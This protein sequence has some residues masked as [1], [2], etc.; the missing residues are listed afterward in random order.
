MKRFHLTY[1]VTE[2]ML[3]RDFLTAKGISKRT[4]T[5]IKYEGGS[6]YVNEV[7]QNVRY[8]VK[9]GDIVSIYFPIERLSDGLTAEQGE[10]DVIYEDEALLL[11]NKSAAMSTIP[12]AQHRSHT[13]ANYVAGKFAKEAV[14]ATVHIVTRLDY[15]TSGL[16]CIAK[17]R[18]IHHLLSEQI[19]QGLFDRKYEA[20]VEGHIVESHFT[21]NQP[22]GRKEG[23][24]IERM[25]CS[26]GQSAITHVQV[27]KRFIQQDK[28]FTLV[29]LTLETGRTHQIRVHLASIGHPL[30]GDDLYGGERAQISRQALHCKALAFQHPLH[31]KQ[32]CFKS[33]LP[34]DMLSLFE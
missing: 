32:V 30:A 17:N 5:A 33:E 9:S 11:V 29:E 21:I 28:S 2:Q 8:K 15:D 31:E 6:I 22:I 20:I 1:Q 24:I 12:S 14:P 23:S 10:L 7:E 18:H 3:L 4:L 13:V 34:G 27:Q 19:Q 25:I 16:V 26:D